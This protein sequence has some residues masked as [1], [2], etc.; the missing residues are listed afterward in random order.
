ML[1]PASI[2][3]GGNMRRTVMPQELNELKESI[4]SLRSIE[5]GIEGSGILQALLVRPFEPRQL[6]ADAQVEGKFKGESNEQVGWLEDKTTQ[7]RGHYQLICGQKRFLVAKSLGLPAIPC[8]IDRR[9]TA[10]VY[11]NKKGSMD[12]LNRLL[13]LTENA[14]RSDPP[15]LEEAEAL[16]DTMRE[17]RL[18]VRDAARL[19]GKNKGYIENRLRLLKM[20]P[21]VQRMVSLRKDTIPHAYYIGPIND[22]ELRS[23]LIAAVLNEQIGVREVRRRIELARGESRSEGSPETEDLQINP[24]L[25][26]G[27]SEDG[28]A[29]STVHALENHDSDVPDVVME[30]G[31]ATLVGTIETVNGDVPPG[32]RRDYIRQNLRPAVSLVAQAARYIDLN[33]MTENQRRNLRIEIDLLR[34]QIQAIEEQISR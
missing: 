13:Q 22:D 8:L 34:R 5:E 2:A 15:P 17:M 7:T 33:R 28:Q 19:L 10:S 14:Q 9:D 30:T 31:I 18:S 32:H 4:T 16:L 26:E 12:A 11:P 27:L 21:D 23:R 24:E 6:E 1:P 3:L 25:S 29:T 20:G